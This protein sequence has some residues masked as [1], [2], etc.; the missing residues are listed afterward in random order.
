MPITS[1][2]YAKWISLSGKN[3]T[4]KIGAETYPTGTNFSNFNLSKIETA[5]RPAKPLYKIKEGIDLVLLF[6]DNEDGQK[7]KLSFMLESFIALTFIAQLPDLQGSNVH[8][9]FSEDN[10]YYKMSLATYIDEKVKMYCKQ[11]YKVRRVGENLCLLD[12]ETEQQTKVS[13]I[14]KTACQALKIELQFNHTKTRTDESAAEQ[15]RLEQEEKRKEAEKYQQ[16]KAQQINE[17]DLPF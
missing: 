11:N 1:N 5:H 8:F 17:D 6:T 14:L 16:A 7:Y 12:K 10:G 13:D 9:F 3:G 4:L 2:D 15:R